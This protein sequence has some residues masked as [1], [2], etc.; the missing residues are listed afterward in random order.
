[1]SPVR[2]FVSCACSLLIWA[3]CVFIFLGM[4]L[5]IVWGDL[6]VEAASAVGQTL[7]EQG[8]NPTQIVGCLLFHFAVPPLA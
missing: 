5:E 8:L 6:V 3:C 4:M 1:M 2:R 7:L